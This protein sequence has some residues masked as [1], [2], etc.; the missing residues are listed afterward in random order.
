MDELKKFSNAILGGLT[1]AQNAPGIAGISD[2]NNKAF[3]ASLRAP[4]VESAFGVG[5]VA[6]NV[7]NREEQQRRAAEQERMQ[8]L[9]DM[10]D[11]SK[12]QRLRK[13]DGG[14][15]FLD[16][17]GKEIGIDTYSARTGQRPAEIL[18]DS[19]NPLD[20]QYVNDYMNM[21]KLMQAAFNGESSAVNSIL[22][23]SGLST[24]EKPE[25]YMRQLIKKYPHIYG[26]G[27]Y[28]DSRRNLNNPVFKFPTDDDEDEGLF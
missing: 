5:G 24:E 2:A 27:G 9:K 14:F 7:A 28:D 22:K 19:D 15:K 6:S 11:P 18:K 23:K 16:P 8:R 10:V 13:E 26:V 12:Y 3:A 1:S 4:L 17:T 25:S 20:R 21:N